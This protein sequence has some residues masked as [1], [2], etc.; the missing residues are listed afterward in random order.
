MS[1][2]VSDQ[3]VK[4]AERVHANGQLVALLDRFKDVKSD[5]E[6]AALT[7]LFVK[8]ATRAG[9]QEMLDW[10]LLRPDV[11]RWM[12]P[13]VVKELRLAFDEDNCNHVRELLETMDDI[14]VEVRTKLAIE[15]LENGNLKMWAELTKNGQL[16]L[17]LVSDNFRCLRLLVA[18]LGRLRDENLQRRIME[19]MLKKLP[20]DETTRTACI[21]LIAEYP[22]YHVI[23]PL[24]AK[25]T[26]QRTGVKRKNDDV[27]QEKPSVAKISSGVS[28]QLVRITLDLLKKTNSHDTSAEKIQEIFQTALG[29]KIIRLTVLANLLEN[30]FGQEIGKAYPSGTY[31][32][33]VKR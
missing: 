6:G 33:L 12:L 9:N 2:S 13:N 18:S 11:Q 32:A 31:Y 21:E 27:E 28:P 24:L 4:F 20:N 29:G 25:F 22:K 16:P 3:T 17:E 15:L 8:T 23:I 10:V 7:T 26:M 5:E 1:A 14:G 19:S 30:V